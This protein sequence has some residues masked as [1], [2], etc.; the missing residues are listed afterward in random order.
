MKP[1]AS[2]AGMSPVSFHLPMADMGL[3]AAGAP[4]VQTHRFICV[5]H[6]AGIDQAF[7]VFD[8]NVGGGGT[9]VLSFVQQIEI[10]E[11]FAVTQEVRITAAT[12]LPTKMGR[13]RVFARPGHVLYLR[14]Q[15]FPDG[16][17]TPP[18][19]LTTT[20]LSGT[21]NLLSTAGAGEQQ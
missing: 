8:Q 11:V 2:L 14:I 10:G 9:M 19:W 15:A 12:Q 21:I 13:A 4:S 7:V 6:D 20:R 18:W 5:L 16:S 3:P 1:N 17:A